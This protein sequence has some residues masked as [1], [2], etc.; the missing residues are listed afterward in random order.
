MSLQDRKKNGLEKLQKEIDKMNKPSAQQGDDRFWK[1]SL[2]AA[3]NG[4]AT[5]RFLDAPEGETC[6]WIALWKYGFVGPSGLWYIEKSLTNLNKPDPC[7]ELHN[8]LWKTG[9]E[10]NQNIVRKQKSKKR[11]I[12]NI[13]VI[14]DPANP[15]NEGKV[16][17]YEFG[18]KIFGM[19]ERLLMPEQVEDEDPVESINPFDFWKG[20]NFKMKVKKVAGYANYD[21]C[22][23][24]PVSALFD[25]D[26]A[27]IEAI[28]KQEHK[29]QEFVDPSTFKT[30][31]ELKA[32][33]DK[34]LGLGDNSE[35][36]EKISRKQVEAK[37]KKE[38][39]QTKENEKEYDA[40]I[41]SEEFEALAALIE[42]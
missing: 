32:R 29:L 38:L 13:L 9:V 5:I 14:K 42:E 31:D 6:P 8:K 36:E 27:K 34:V 18:T 22:K 4:T 28:F 41:D 24:S 21:D 23:F 11:F 37:P 1:L 20:C 26:D 19:I 17:L 7:Y 3:G 2:D 35:K 15:Q 39:E 40:D 25:G 10:E 33:L 16:F 12:S 30:Y